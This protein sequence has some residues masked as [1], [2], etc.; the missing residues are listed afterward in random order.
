MSFFKPLRRQGGF[1][2]IL[3]VAGI[4]VS[5]A[6]AGALITY[7]LLKRQAGGDVDFQQTALQAAPSHAAF[8]LSFDLQ[9]MGMDSSLLQEVFKISKVKQ[10]YDE[11]KTEFKNKSGQDWKEETIDILMP[12]SF[13]ISIAPD[14]SLKPGE[15]A[16]K[17][18][19][20]ELGKL[21]LVV[22]LE[23]SDSAK[24]LTLMQDLAKDQLTKSQIRTESYNGATLYLPP[25]EPQFQ[26]AFAIRDGIF[27]ASPSIENLKLALDGATKAGGLGTSDRFKAAM[28][29]FASFDDGAFFVD[30]KSVMAKMPPLPPE[31]AQ[32]PLFTKLVNSFE[33]IASGGRIDADKR[34]TTHLKLKFGIPAGDALAGIFAP[35]GQ[36]LTASRV[37]PRPL[38]TYASYNLRPLY[39]MVMRGLAAD[40]SSQALAQMPAAMLMEKGIDLQKDILDVITGELA[41]ALSPEVMQL[42]PGQDD[43]S[44]L[45]SFGGSGEA[46]ELFKSMGVFVALGLKDVAK[47]EALLTKFAG[48]ML[49]QT[50]AEDYK[51]AKIR[52]MGPFAMGYVDNFLVLAG[53][54]GRE[55]LVKLLDGA[56]RLNSDDQYKRI[57][58][59]SGKSDGLIESYMDT[60]GYMK[61][62]MSGSGMADLKR[63]FTA[64]DLVILQKIYSRLGISL[65]RVA[66]VADGFEIQTVTQFK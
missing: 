4:L 2:K 24:W 57:P 17:L 39:D 43:L 56:P 55:R 44:M 28:S 3:V 21:G 48:P 53:L 63:E 59:T 34:G 33:W 36:S 64:E 16:D 20:K 41:F 19:Q 66:L 7:K 31:V 25:A 5:I 27:W 40:P 12:K 10:G 62:V 65:G 13:A 45:S 61:T 22:M 8:F 49:E 6:A 15:L 38:I 11:F 30:V 9:K 18:K 47:F 46:A 35:S 26:S 52:A 37:M 23:L 50:P 54:G 58:P 32:Q 60:D 51:G 42:P 1:V 14:A 29:E